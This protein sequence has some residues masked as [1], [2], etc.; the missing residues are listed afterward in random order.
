[1]KINTLSDKKSQYTIYNIL[2]TENGFTLIELLVVISII[3]ILVGISIFGLSGAREASR[4]ARR[5]SDLE[6]IRSGLELYKADCNTYPAAAPAAGAN[7]TGT[8][9]PTSCNANNVYIAGFPSD[10]VSSA[11]SYRY[12]FD[13][14][15]G[16]YLLCASLENAPSPAMDVTGCGSCTATCNYKV[17]N[18]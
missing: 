10:P 2:Y 8:G 7:L 12:T 17:T 15:S 16:T 9:T 14:T 13:G 1:M 18:P 5:K 6:L 4:D 3:A 11:R